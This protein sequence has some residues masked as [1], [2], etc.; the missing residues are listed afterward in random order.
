MSFI[1]QVGPGPPIDDGAQLPALN[2]FVRVLLVGSLI[3]PT[4]IVAVLIEGYPLI[5]PFFGPG[6]FLG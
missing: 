2:Y 4:P 6:H 5:C 3:E 1:A